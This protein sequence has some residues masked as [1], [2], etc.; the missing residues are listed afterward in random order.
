MI[1]K[2]VTKVLYFGLILDISIK[3]MFNFRDL[4]NEEG[5]V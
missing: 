2:E 4:K 5:M 1:M 3:E